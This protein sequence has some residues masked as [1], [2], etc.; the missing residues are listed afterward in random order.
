MWP[1]HAKSQR[2]QHLSFS[3]ES[4]DDVLEFE[5]FAN[6]E[7]LS[8]DVNMAFCVHQTDEA[9]FV[10]QRWAVSSRPH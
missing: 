2:A 8:Q 1:F 10:L 3:V 9:D 7:S 4:R 5:P 6:L